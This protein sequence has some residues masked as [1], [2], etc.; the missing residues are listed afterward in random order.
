ME[1]RVLNTI[2]KYNLIESGD[3]VICGVSGGPDSICMLDILR[4]IKENKIINLELIVCH[5]NH[6]IR[7]EA[8]L[9]EKYVESYCKKNNIKFYSKR[10]DI[11]QVANNKKQGTEEAGRI[12]RYDFFEEIL[13]KDGVKEH[14]S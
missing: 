11:K 9:D 13:K 14:V 1:D 4:K 3:K 8:D 7:D 5:I 12:A 6:L 2:K 10:I